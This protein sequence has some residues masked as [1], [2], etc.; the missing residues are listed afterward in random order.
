MM[1][2]GVAAI[3]KA[4][5]EE[6]EAGLSR[7][8]IQ[9]FG[10]CSRCLRKRR[11]MWAGRFTTWVRPPSNINSWARVQAHKSGDEV[12]VFSRRLNEVTEAVPEVVEAVRA[13]PAR[14]LVLDGE[15]LTSI[16]RIVPGRSR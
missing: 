4:L 2:G 8:S 7:F 15:V 13:L 5:M 6:G 14:T 9:L 1:A 12:R 11:K 3:A 10:R 16:R